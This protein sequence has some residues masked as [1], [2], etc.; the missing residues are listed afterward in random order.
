MIK[1][2]PKKRLKNSYAHFSSI[3]IQMFV[4]IGIGSYSGV[5]LDQ[6]YPNTYN[7]YTICI[8]LV[9]V[10]LAIVFVIKRIISASKDN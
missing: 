3:A 4:I 9:S 10:I 5:K 6:K 2:N 7:L 8:S 1:K